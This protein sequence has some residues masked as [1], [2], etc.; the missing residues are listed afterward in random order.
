MPQ[1][2]IRR[3]HRHSLNKAKAAVKKTAAA[4]SEKFDIETSW[5]GNTLNFTRPGVTG[6]IHISDGEVH[7][8]ADLGF[9]LGMLKPAI[10][11]EI[12]QQLDE[13]FG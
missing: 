12:R 11:R 2:D 5:S 9:L 7:V 10:E 1:I 8:V 6:A 13:Q 4:I 3:K